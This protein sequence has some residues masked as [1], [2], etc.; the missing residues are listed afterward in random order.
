MSIAYSRLYTACTSLLSLVSTDSEGREVKEERRR[1]EELYFYLIH[2]RLAVSWK[3]ICKRKNK[4]D[5]YWLQLEC[6][7]YLK[8]LLSRFVCFS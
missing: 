4:K 8:G 2:T 1:F 5:Q 3:Y 7:S 6:K